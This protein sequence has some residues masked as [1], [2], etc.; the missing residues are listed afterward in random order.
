MN[1]PFSGSTLRA[2]T[3]PLLPLSCSFITQ[4]H[5]SSKTKSYRVFINCYACSLVFLVAGFDEV[6]SFVAF[7]LFSSLLF[8][9]VGASP[10]LSVTWLHKAGYLM[11]MLGQTLSCAVKLP[12]LVF[13]LCCTYYSQRLFCNTYCE[14]SVIHRTTS[15]H[16]LNYSTQDSRGV[17]ICGFS[18]FCCKIR[19]Y[20]DL[21]T[22]FFQFNHEW[23]QNKYNWIIYHFINS[24]SLPE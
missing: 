13:F 9:P 17:R 12:I 15:F 2:E 10:A 23:L 4:R 11:L 22:D 20:W 18:F 14:G 8:K 24:Y 6:D 19:F 16:K 7:L 21:L 5:T 1:A 3:K